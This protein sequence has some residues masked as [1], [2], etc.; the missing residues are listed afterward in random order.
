MVQV[1]GMVVT[2]P[3]VEGGWLGALVDADAMVEVVVGGAAVASSPPEQPAMAA[4]TM[5]AASR[6]RGRGALVWV[7]S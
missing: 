4:M 2:R 5:T 3:S 6:R 1:G 7:T